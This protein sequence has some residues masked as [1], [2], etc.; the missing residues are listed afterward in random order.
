MAKLFHMDPNHCSPG[1]L[2]S[3]MPCLRTGLFVLVSRVSVSRAH[4][5][6]ELLLPL[7]L[8]RARCVELCH[9]MITIIIEEEWSQ[10]GQSALSGGSPACARV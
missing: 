8:D 4:S 5:N 1:H 2:P 9:V 6:K 7:V 10:D 3:Q